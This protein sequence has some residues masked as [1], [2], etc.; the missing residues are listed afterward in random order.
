[1]HRRIDAGFN[2]NMVNNPSFMHDGS[3]LEYSRISDMTINHGRLSKS[4]GGKRGC[5]SIIPIMWS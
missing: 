1:M 3:V 5:S 4:E 2:V